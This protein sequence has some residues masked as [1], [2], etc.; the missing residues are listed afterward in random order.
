MNK[1]ISKITL[2]RQVDSNPDLSW[3]EHKY[4]FEGTDDN[5]RNLRI[6]DSCRYTQ[7]DV[8]KYGSKKVL[9]WIRDDE[10]MMRT[11]GETWWYVGIS[12]EA[13]VALPHKDSSSG[14]YVVTIQSDGV[15][16]VDSDPQHIKQIENELLEDIKQAL[17]L[18][19]FTEDEINEAI[20]KLEEKER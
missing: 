10:H 16:G 6:I 14:C 2:V 12:A 4:V 9:S 7:Q 20:S 19:E 5:P 17:R 13:V 8:N 18:F 11:Y 1:Q 15:W 3:L